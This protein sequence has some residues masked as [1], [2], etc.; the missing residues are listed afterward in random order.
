MP[1]PND[2]GLYFVDKAGKLVDEGSP[3]VAQ[4]F[5]E[6]DLRTHKLGPYADAKTQKQRDDFAAAQAAEAEEADQDRV[7]PKAGRSG[8]N[9]ATTSAPADKSRP[10]LTSDTREDR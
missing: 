3:D 1:K 5:T 9:K 6:E 7:E 8:A 10:A 2:A 4:Q